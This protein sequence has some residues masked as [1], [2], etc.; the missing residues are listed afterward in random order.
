MTSTIS[1]VTGAATVRKRGRNGSR[2]HTA[3]EAAQ[4]GQH[5]ISDH[6]RKFGEPLP[7]NTAPMPAPPSWF[8]RE[9]KEIFAA[10][11]A[12][13]PPG[14]LQA[15]DFE[16]LVTLANAVLMHRTVAKEMLALP[17]GA[18]PQER[19][20]LERRLRFASS[21]VGRISKTLGLT[22]PERARIGLPATTDKDKTD[23]W[24][25]FPTMIDVAK[26]A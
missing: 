9:L 13:A 5:A 12:F 21:A 26:A 16:N 24:T 20:A 8:S 6:R 22:P 15:G 2:R 3:A 10:T 4:R 14:L 7:T 1:G 11:I 23:Q 18:L 19:E 17:R 25:P